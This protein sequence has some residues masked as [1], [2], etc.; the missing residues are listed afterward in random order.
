MVDWDSK[1]RGVRL[2]DN[3]GMHGIYI[4]CT[5]CVRSVALEMAEAHRLFG[6]EAHTRD[7][8]RRLRCTEC[9]QRRGYVMM[10]ATSTP[11]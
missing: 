9:G 5:P 1:E 3:P 2:S 6:A 11:H 10:W 8:A 7:I 4:G